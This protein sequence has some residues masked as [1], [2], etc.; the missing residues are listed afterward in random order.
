METIPQARF[1]QT[2]SK[3]LA[4]EKGKGKPDLAA[5]L[6]AARA[7]VADDSFAVAADELIHRVAQG[8]SL[9]QAMSEQRDI[10]PVGIVT[11]VR[12]SEAG[13]TLHSAAGYI[14]KAVQEGLF[15]LPGQPAKGEPAVRF[16]KI[17]GTM[18]STAVPILQVF[19]VLRDEMAEGKQLPWSEA[20]ATMR[21]AILAGQ[22]IPQVMESLP[23]LFDPRIIA[24]IDAGES[25][26]ELDRVA[27]RIADALEKGNLSDLPVTQVGPANTGARTSGVFVK[28]VEQALS[29]RASDLVFESLDGGR[30]R[31]RQRID[32]VM[33]DVCTLPEGSSLSLI[34]RIKM[35]ATMNVAERQLPQDGRMSLELGGRTVD[36]RISSVPGIYG[37]RLCLRLLHRQAMSFDLAALGL[38]PENLATTRRFCHLPQGIVVI[39]GPTGAGKTTA[40]YSMLLESDQV[41]QTIIT[42]EDPVEYAFDRITQIQIRPE[43]GLTFV[44]A[45]RSLLRQDPDTIM[46][47]EI[48]DRETLEICVQCAMTGHLVLTTLHA[49][50]C[51]A[52][53]RRMLD[54]GVAA[55]MLNASLAGIISMRLAR[56][57]C[58]HCKHPARPDLS[59]APR[60]VQEILDQQ[61]EST[62]FEAK[63]CPSCSQ[64]G[65]VGRIALYEILA[66]N[67]ELR[68][69]VS[70]DATTSQLRE[71]AVRTGMKTMLEDGVVKAVSGTTSLEEVLRVVPVEAYE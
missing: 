5:A 38:T 66:I 47:G 23:S 67:D 11:M 24:A 65:Y 56:K 8:Q 48:R 41:S 52:A 16:W 34:N 22:P 68:Q 25:T 64:T 46:I 19:E 63:G 45:I 54:I 14:A 53:I 49:N 17:L 42:V 29:S 31:V 4:Q 1:W 60:R 55:F 61:K 62:L 43:I 37:E 36:V 9:S 21:Q 57:L 51:A 27:L 35:M 20:A 32:G 30:I 69:S 10:F 26:G 59:K 18:M 50:T 44:R 3:E 12:A 6:K 39:N 70:T 71:V 15:S 28:L 7:T 40:L 2:L 13:G 58:P 33:H